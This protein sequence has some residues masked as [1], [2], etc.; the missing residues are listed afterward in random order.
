MIGYMQIV[1]LIFSLILVINKN[2]SAYEGDRIPLPEEVLIHAYRLL[3]V[4]PAL[5]PQLIGQIAEMILPYVQQHLALLEGDGID[6]VER[7]QYEAT[8]IIK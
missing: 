8:L 2:S 7:A 5:V 4:A 3:E 6:S 1:C